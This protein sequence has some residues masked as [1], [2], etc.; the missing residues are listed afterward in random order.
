MRYLAAACVGFV[1][2]LLGCRA[3]PQTHP[4][5][6]A[7]TQPI[8]E[9]NISAATD[10]HP[11]LEIYH[12]L[13]SRVMERV[14][15]S[16]PFE[17]S[18]EFNAKAPPFLP[19]GRTCRVLADSGD[20]V[21]LVTDPG[22]GVDYGYWLCTDHMTLIDNATGAVIRMPASD[23]GTAGTASGVGAVGEMRL[24]WALLAAAA[25]DEILRIAGGRTDVRLSRE[26]EHEMYQLLFTGREPVSG[27]NRLRIDDTAAEQ[28]ITWSDFGSPIFEMRTRAIRQRGAG[29]LVPGCVGGCLNLPAQVPL[30]P[31]PGCHR[32]LLPAEGPGLG[33]RLSAQ[34]RGSGG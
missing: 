3:T 30:G 22:A 10:S 6:T 13:V 2:I 16:G 4:A 24:S 19:G 18:F 34:R 17:L 25:R 33:D 27:W 9:C 8:S 14:R 5:A 31:W 20:V 15:Q 21:F 29:R 32:R 23:P 11:V 28:K 26:Q 1:A 12:G 7:N